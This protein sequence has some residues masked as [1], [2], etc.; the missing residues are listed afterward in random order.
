MQRI[1]EY[2]N[3]LHDLN[4][5]NNS[6]NIRNV[7]HHPFAKKEAEVEDKSKS[8]LLRNEQTP[9]KSSET[10]KL[11][12]VNQ[13][14]EYS[15]EFDVNEIIRKSIN[16]GNARSNVRNAKFKLKQ[17]QQV[18]INGSPIRNRKLKPTNKRLIFT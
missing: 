11:N 4:Y 15:G 10:L 17:A 12:S 18:D 14:E 5:R 13:S 8:F 9:I 16:R 1:E 7:L 3:K 6:S 2:F